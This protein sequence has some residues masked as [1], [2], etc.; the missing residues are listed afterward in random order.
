MGH[1][2]ALK[3]I[4]KDLLLEEVSSKSSSLYTPSQF[5]P[6]NPNELYQERGNYELYDKMR[7]DEQV[8]AVL[9]LKKHVIL[10][11]GWELR[12]DRGGQNLGKEKDMLEDNLKFWL[13]NSFENI[14]MQFLTALDYGFSISEVIYRLDN[15]FLWI[16]DIK[17]RPPHGFLFHQDEF[18]NVIKIV[19][20]TSGFKNIELNPLKFIVF[21]YQE[22]FQNP[23]GRSDLESAYRAWWSKDIIIKFWNIYLERNAVPAV[24]GKY[25]RNVSQK[26]R[27][28]FLTLLDNIQN[29]SSLILPEDLTI[30]LLET[31]R[32]ATPDFEKAIDKYNLMIAR[33]LLMPD[34]MGLAGS[35]TA[36]GSYALG[37]KHFDLFLL[38][39]SSIQKDLERCINNRLIRP[40]FKL[41]FGIEENYPLFRFIEQTEEN[42]NE[43]A[44]T[45][46]DAV[47]SG[48]IGASNDEQSHFRKIVGFPDPEPSDESELSESEQ[49]QAEPQDKGIS[50]NDTVVK[51]GDSVVNFRFKIK[52]I[53]EKMTEGY[54]EDL[55]KTKFANSK[56]K[57]RFNKELNLALKSELRKIYEAQHK[58]YPNFK[59]LRELSDL[60]YDVSGQ[61]TDELINRADVL[62]KDLQSDKINLDKINSEIQKSFDF[63][64]EY[65]LDS[66]YSKIKIYIK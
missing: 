47:K 10:S 13:E 39:I 62:I 11:N 12:L 45:W 65:N 36:G 4:D 29:K 42:K 3:D 20:Q 54:L 6:Y 66:L 19:Q 25:K 35:Q 5:E 9:S 14:L 21:S 2:Q 16:K 41:N 52:P 48:V 26:V 22:E 46:L 58:K 49:T 27:E 33:S 30:E 24:I 43:L 63:V 23:Y 55:T 50:E 15:D 56:L 38:V 32:S 59:D 44:K 51:Q 60:A 53:I 1:K 31:K 28:R 37:Q 18:G 57:I 34:L 17:T 61:I 40:F 64:K 8:K 7:L